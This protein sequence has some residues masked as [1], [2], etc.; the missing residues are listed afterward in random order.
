MN[1]YTTVP[2]TIAYANELV[3]D[4]IAFEQH[5]YEFRLTYRDRPRRRDWVNGILRARS[6]DLRD[7]PDERGSERMR[8]LNVLR[9]WRCMDDL[10][11]QVCG[12]PATDQES[13]LTP[14]LLVETVFEATGDD[15][16]R[17][18]APPTCWGCIPKALEEC[19]ML[20]EKATLCTVETALSAGVLAD[21]Y[22]PVNGDRP[23][24]QRRNVF[25]AWDA[26]AYHPYALAVAQV[27]ELHGMRPVEAATPLGIGA[28]R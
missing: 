18:N 16:G 2:Y 15:C 4:P 25:V 24:L 8:K 7:R 10:L 11:C 27:V 28:Q 20:Q 23:R 3:K 19:P 22:W 12:E 21:L 9:Q 26:I 5:D 14:W 1:G 17:T 13:S 6:L